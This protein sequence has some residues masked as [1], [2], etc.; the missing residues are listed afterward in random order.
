M[1]SAAPSLSDAIAIDFL[2]CP[3]CLERLRRPKILPCLHTYCQGCLEGLL[4]AG[5]GLRCPECREDVSLPQ[6]VA[7]LK[8]NFFVNGLLELVRPAGEAGLTC[9]L[10][11]LIGQEGGRPAV[12]RCLD[13]ADSLCQACAA[14]HRCSRLTHAHRLVSLQGYLSGEHDAEIRQRQAARCP[15]H[16]AEE[17]RF[18]CQPCASPLCRE[19]RL[20]PHLEHPCQTLEEAAEARRPLVAELLAGVEEAAGRV[21]RGRAALEE[22]LEQLR[23]HEAG[24]RD[25][26]KRACAD[27]ARRLLAQQE[28]VLAALRRHVEGR[29]TAAGLLRTELQLQEQLARGTADVARQVLA[30]GRPVEI[31]SLEALLTQR[32]ARLRG[33]HWEPL[34]GPR[35]RLVVRA[36]LQ[37]LSSLFQLD[38]GEA[39]PQGRG[40]DRAQHDAPSLEPSASA[41][42]LPAPS[43]KPRAP[44]LEPSASAPELPAPSPKPRAPSLEP[45]AS[46]PELPA[47]SP[48]PRAPSLEPSA[49]APELLDPAPD[50]PSC[51]PPPT[52]RFSCS[53]SVRVPGDKH[54]PRVT[55]LCPLGSRELLLADEENRSLKR[56]SLQGDFRGAVPV[57]GGVAPCSVAAVGSRVAY[58]AGSRLYLAERDGALVWQKALRPTQASHAV[59]PA[60][61]GGEAVAVSVAGH[62][63]V[64]DARGE[65]V[66]K[67]FPDGHDRLAMVFVAGR[68]G[69]Y[70]AS[71][72]HR[73]SVVAFD[74]HGQL[75]AELGE[76]RL[77]RCQPGAVCAD[78]RGHF[79]VTLRELNKV[80]AFGPGGEALGPFL[81]AR[82]GIERARVATVT[83]DGH[84]AVALSDGTVHI[85]RIQYPG[86]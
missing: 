49:S 27:A 82:H 2:T 31:V 78:D 30:L 41:P 28:E 46:A 43:P 75:L 45:S 85:F 69:R 66:E 83:G 21:A 65:L 67:I 77:E 76:E 58:T 14:G 32:L 10:C 38:V 70:V 15:E 71:D 50:P 24:L 20:G 7:G 13:C 25:V 73:R 59:T 53:F 33:F 86:Q 79:Y 62:L 80:M 6:G 44:S 5:P 3:I 12:A 63:E 16:P 64:Y 68:R 4:G 57:H 8:T 22:E 34:G 37:N 9:A 11:P 56:F 26:V 54:R 19:C 55:G 17:V 51:R 36:D 1:A 23:R 81:T 60:A 84:F 39:E 52:A 74:G 18:F 61:E 42:E 48:K 29:E 40:E 47:L 72:W 35:P